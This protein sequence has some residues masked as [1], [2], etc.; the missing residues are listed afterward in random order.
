MLDHCTVGIGI[1]GIGL[2]GGIVFFA[3][4]VVYFRKVLHV[5][6]DLRRAVPCH[7]GFQV[8]DHRISNRCYNKRVL[9]LDL[10]VSLSGFLVNSDNNFLAQAIKSLALFGGKIHRIE[11]GIRI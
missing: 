1:V 8:L 9:H 3:T 7:I 6:A 2:L 5:L 4:L 10:D 11:N